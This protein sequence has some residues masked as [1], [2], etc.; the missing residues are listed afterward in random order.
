LFSP[1]KFTSQ[2]EFNISR[3]ISL[4]TYSERAFDNNFLFLSSLTYFNIDEI[5]NDKNNIDI[6]SNG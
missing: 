6:N 5:K 2:V 1:D 3:A 4:D